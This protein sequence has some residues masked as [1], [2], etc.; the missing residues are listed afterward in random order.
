MT[1]ALDFRPYFALLERRDGAGAVRHAL[2]LIDGGAD[3]VDVLLDVV[4]PAQEQVGRRWAE[5]AWTV[6][7]E[8]AATAISE[9]VAMAVGARIPP[10]EAPLGHVILACAEREWH[11]LPARLVGY[12]LQAAGWRTTF[13]G[14]STS[15]RQF[16]RFLD[17][18]DADAVAISCSV[19]A[20]LPAARRLIDAAREAGLP[21][22]VG[23]GAFGSDDTRARALGASGWAR[24]ARTASA[25]LAELVAAAGAQAWASELRWATDRARHA[26]ADEHAEMTIRFAEFR[27]SARRRWLDAPADP[28]GGPPDGSSLADDA[29]DHALHALSAA[30]LTDDPRLLREASDWLT[31]LLTARGERP[32]VVASLWR[33]VHQTVGEP[34]PEAARHL[35]TL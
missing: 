1:G 4:A 18:V 24:D 29:V 33:S 8:H 17:D 32:D 11:G 9:S 15:P 2:G 21:V 31:A 27:A 14:A 30:L 19:A 6:A 12:C 35:K 3:P 22:L 20:S 7:H 26:G 16:A 10:P 25:V 34:L 23:G 5:G 28:S 13:L